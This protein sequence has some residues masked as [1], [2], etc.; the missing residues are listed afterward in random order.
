[1]EKLKVSNQTKVTIIVC[2]IGFIFVGYFS[3]KQYIKVTNCMENYGEYEY[4]AKERC[5][6][7]HSNKHE[8]ED[9]EQYKR[10]VKDA[11]FKHDLYEEVE[12]M[13]R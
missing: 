6:R 2:L 12:R 1:M 9:W 13:N 10:D 7:N 8:V 3:A 5:Y 4:S 11:K